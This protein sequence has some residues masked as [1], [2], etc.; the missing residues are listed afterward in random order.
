[1]YIALEPSLHPTTTNTPGARTATRRRAR[2]VVAIK[3]AAAL[4]WDD[5]PPSTAGF[6]RWAAAVGHRIDEHGL[7]AVT[8]ELDHV[9]AV[10]RRHGVAPVAADVLADSTQPEPARQRAFAHVV[11]ALVNAY[12]SSTSGRS[13]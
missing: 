6:P 2:D 1:M 4:T 9:V 12:A 8:R 5:R 7:A 11:S 3:P 10:A 13:S